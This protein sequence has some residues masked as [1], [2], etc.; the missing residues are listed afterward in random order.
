M[1]WIYLFFLVRTASQIERYSVT[2]VISYC[3][4]SPFS[5]RF[6]SNI[7]HVFNLLYHHELFFIYLKICSTTCARTR[8]KSTHVH[9]TSTIYLVS[10]ASTL[11]V[12]RW[13]RERQLCSYTFA[14]LYLHIVGA[15][16]HLATVFVAHP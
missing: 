16:L 10:A 9:K 11:L 12:W 6:S 5:T 13:P 8:Y 4:F 15:L 14:S 1:K 7:L 3:L 2:S